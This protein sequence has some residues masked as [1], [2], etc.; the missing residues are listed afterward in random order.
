MVA[1]LGA[2]RLA[3]GEREGL[4]IKAQ[5]RWRIEDLTPPG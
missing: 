3:A 4:S 2:V 5:P 1:Y